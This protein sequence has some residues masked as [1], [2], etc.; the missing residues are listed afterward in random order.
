VVYLQVWIFVHV[1]FSFSLGAPL[2]ITEAQARMA[3]ALEGFENY[4]QSLATGKLD[5][6]FDP[7]RPEDQ[8]IVPEVDLPLGPGLIL[9]LHDLGKHPNVERTRK[10]FSDETVFVT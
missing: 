7:F 10:L 6:Y 3:S 9:L 4:I 2:T 1:F 5:G 8:A